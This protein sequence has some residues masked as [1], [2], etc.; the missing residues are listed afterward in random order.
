[1]GL[2]DSNV[3][4]TICWPSVSTDKNRKKGKPFNF[5]AVCLVCT[6]AKW[7]GQTL[8]RGWSKLATTCSATEQQSIIS[9]IIDLD[10]HLDPQAEFLTI[11]YGWKKN[12]ADI[13]L[14][15]IIALSKKVRL[16]FGWLLIFFLKYSWRVVWK[17]FSEAKSGITMYIGTWKFWKVGSHGP[18]LS[19]VARHCLAYWYS[20]SLTVFFSYNSIRLTE[21]FWRLFS[22][23]KFG[24]K[25]G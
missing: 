16:K 15:R 4:T 20:S 14:S 6:E 17:Y 13:R 9:N 2:R 21:I 25:Y 3:P 8:T 1:M 10:L 18:S 24:G 11:T 5:L 12:S 23:Q 19:S 22:G 7:N